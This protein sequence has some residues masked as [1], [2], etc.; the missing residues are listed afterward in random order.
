MRD[1]QQKETRKTDM[2]FRGLPGQV[3]AQPKKSLSK[4]IHYFCA[5]IQY[6]GLHVYALIQYTAFIHAMEHSITG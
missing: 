3:A 1:K 2:Q 5:C 6:F 4:Y